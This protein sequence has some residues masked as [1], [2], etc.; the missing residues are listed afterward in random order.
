MKQRRI[1]IYI[2]GGSIMLALTVPLAILYVGMYI[3]EKKE[4]H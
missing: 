3:I 4:A 2:L 1:F